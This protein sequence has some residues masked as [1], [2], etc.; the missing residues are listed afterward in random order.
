[1]KFSIE[2]DQILEALQKVQSIVGQRTTL[3][4]LSNVLLEADNGKLTLTTTDM[5]VS[6]R[7]ALDADISE[8]GATTLP[9]R[10]FFSI[11]RDLPSHQID[12][13][14]NNSDMAEISS[15]AYYGKLEGLSK[16]DFPPMPTFEESSSYQLK[17]GT[18]KDILQK[19]SLRGLYG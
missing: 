17:Q 6:V 9:A 12:I 8:A 18:L 15:G 1:M 2:K 5:E 13:A 7:T 16:D 11:C 19:N 3:P 10:R 4:I 14:V